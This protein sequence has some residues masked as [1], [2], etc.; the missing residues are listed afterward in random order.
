MAGKDEGWGKKNLGS[1][2]KGLSILL[3][4]QSPL[5]LKCSYTKFN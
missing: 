2:C 4:P 5:K 3:D 1:V